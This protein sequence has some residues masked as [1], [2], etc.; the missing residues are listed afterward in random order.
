[1][2]YPH[3]YYDDPAKCV[4][5][6]EEYQ[7]GCLGCANR[8]KEDLDPRRQWRCRMAQAVFPDGDNLNCNWWVRNGKQ[9][10]SE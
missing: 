9:S 7:V 1:M 2:A 5:V 4:Q 6:R 8:V 3:Y 10:N